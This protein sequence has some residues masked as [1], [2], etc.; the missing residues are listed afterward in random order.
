MT[1]SDWIV[2]GLVLTVSI[3]AKMIAC[4]CATGLDNIIMG[5]RQNR[6]QAVETYLFG[7]SMVARGEVGLVVATLLYGSQML[8]QSQYSIAVVTI[9]LTTIA[10]PIM[11]SL[12]FTWLERQHLGAD[13]IYTLKLGQFSALGTEYVFALIKK[14]LESSKEYT[15]SAHMSDNDEIISIDDKDLKVILSHDHGIVIKGD[16]A[17]VQQLMTMIKEAVSEDVKLLSVP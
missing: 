1:A 17:H 15:M 11:L 3:I 12:G 14:Q 7:A 8:N 5:Q 4:W 10:A 13:R 2:V 9:V 6:W 16:R